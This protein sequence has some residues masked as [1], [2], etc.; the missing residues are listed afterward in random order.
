MIPA[1]RFALLDM[2]RQTL[3]QPDC[4]VYVHCTRRSVARDSGDV[5]LQVR[6]VN[7]AEREISTVFLCVEGLDFC[8]QVCYQV[9]ELPI[10]D[11]AA[12][13][14][15]VF[16]ENRLLVLPQTK[17]ASLQVTVERVIFADGTRWRR[18]P[19]QRLCSAG[20]AGRFVCAC[21][22]PNPPQRERCLLC[23]R[24]LVREALSEEALAPPAQPALERPAPIV[25][26]FTPHAVWG[27]DS[28]EEEDARMP[29][30]QIAVLCAFGG[31][32]ILA[33]IAFLAFCLMRYGK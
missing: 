19:E 15:R 2:Q 18:Q 9:R 13:P 11:C 23:G 27:E 14:H 29:R 17:I 26:D 21:G 33:A 25:R 24:T 3:L 28:F 20:E 8:G 7:C 16:G 1:E 31:A 4:P 22:L 10:A 32:A 30:W 5:F 6:M 12:A